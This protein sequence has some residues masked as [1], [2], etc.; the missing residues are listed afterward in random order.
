MDAKT[1]RQGIYR[2]ENGLLVN[3]DIEALQQYKTRKKQAAKITAVENDLSSLK[4]DIAE[5]KSMLKGL[6]CK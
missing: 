5:I 3:K 2:T 1:E 4:D 6:F